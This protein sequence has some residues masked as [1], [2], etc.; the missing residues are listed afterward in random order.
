MVYNTNEY[1]ANK[2]QDITQCIAKY[3]IQK[4][5][6]KYRTPVKIYIK[7][8]LFFSASNMRSI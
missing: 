8:Y 3:N 4:L 5:M 6:I 7:C 1:C 2:T